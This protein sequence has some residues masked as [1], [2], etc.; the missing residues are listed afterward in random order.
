M[1]IFHTH[2]VWKTWHFAFIK[3]HQGCFSDIWMRHTW[4]HTA[5]RYWKGLNEVVQALCIFTFVRI[6]FK[7]AN[8][9]SFWRCWSILVSAKCMEAAGLSIAVSLLSAAR[10][11]EWVFACG[12]LLHC[13]GTKWA[14]SKE[15]QDVGFWLEAA[16]L[17]NEPGWVEVGR[18]ANSLWNLTRRLYGVT[19]SLRVVMKINST[20]LRQLRDAKV[21]LCSPHARRRAHF[22]HCIFHAEKHKGFV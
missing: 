20:M 15:E 16:Q 9:K 4:K 22:F 13:H 12:S 1:C 7:F 17:P 18:A 19:V 10:V 11:K 14:W 21:L 5:G 8:A 2:T 6:Y 3:Q